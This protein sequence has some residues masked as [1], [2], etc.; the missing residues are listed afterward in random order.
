MTLNVAYVALASNDVSATVEVLEHLLELPKQWVVSDATG[1][2]VPVFSIGQTALAVFPLGDPL[3]DGAQRPGVHHLALVAA[4]M[5]A[6]QAWLTQKGMKV[7]EQDQPGLGQRRVRL[8]DA[9]TT[10]GVKLRLTSPLSLKPHQGGPIERIDH[11]GVACADVKVSEKIFAQQLGYEVESRQT[12]ME[13]TMAIE[14]FTS[15]KYGVVYHNR[16]PVPQGGLRVCFITVGDF[17]LEFL[18][19]FDPAQGAEVK[20][21]E[22]GNTKGDQG[23]IT[24]FV[25]TRGAGL[26]H[27][28]L[29]AVDINA[30]LARLEQAGIAVI[31]RVGRPGS[32]KAQIG[33]IHPKSLGGVLMHFCQRVEG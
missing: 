6:T 2:Q 3:I 10:D 1:E 23:A 13:V 21:D 24:K 33:F 7:S 8:V 28:A 30:T 27:M 12:D 20:H 14:S 15:D 25:Q 17:E 18:A 11:L 32:R 31:D 29:K 26:H 19:N 9:L 5:Q 4:D 22:P 16:E